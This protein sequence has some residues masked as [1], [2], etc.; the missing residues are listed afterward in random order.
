MSGR[1]FA[2][3]GLLLVIA[4]HPPAGGP[5]VQRD[6]TGGE[7]ERALHVLNRLAYGPRPGDV[8]RV[9]AMG[10]ERYIAEQLSP[11]EI[12]DRQLELRLR[13]F[14]L[15]SVSTT[16]LATLF[17][18]VRRERAEAARRLDTAQERRDVSGRAS[19][20]ALSEPAS[21]LRRL[22]GELRQIT[23]VRAALSER[24]LLEVMADFW[25]NHFNVFIRKGAGRVLVPAHIEEVIRPHVLG[26]FEDL[27]IAT[28]KSPAMLYYLDNVQSVSPDYQPPR[29]VNRTVHPRRRRPDRGTGTS[30]ADSTRGARRPRG[31][32]ENYARELLELHTL[33]VD[34]GYT[35]QDV[36]SVA[37][38]LT[39][40]TVRS[41]DDLR[42]AF[43]ARAHDFGEK[44][45]LGTR[46]SA[47]RGM[48]EGV[49][50]LRLLAAHPST[51]RHVSEKLCTRFVSDQPLPGCVDGAIQAWERTD[52]DIRQVLAAIFRSS[53]F[54]APE[55]RGTKMKTPLEF[56]VSAVRVLNAIPSADPGLAFALRRLGQPLYE[57][58]SPAGYPE[59]QESWVHA[60]ALLER[61][62][63]AVDLAAGTMPGVDV[64]LDDVVPVVGDP[65]H[66]TEAVDAVILTGMASAVTR[67]I[68]RERV[69]AARDPAEA[70]A[71]LVGLAIGSAEFQR[72]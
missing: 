37:R 5:S 25:T 51:R 9:M 41:R 69:D 29:R 10:V 40:W 16:D 1:S 22:M 24:Q 17:R 56:L 55:H 50:M 54:W 52:G 66:L 14:E 39:G 21:R 19:S 27:L 42:F 60:G 43:E 28:A 20:M 13:E 53:E 64:D 58:E 34:G 32:N 65:D 6:G 48:Q 68:L 62:N 11:E 18:T 23:I 31:L 33:G 67:R 15:M 72:Q 3:A 8:E 45:I 70:R 57:Y 30:Q 47:G 7:R 2:V 4:P 38:V 59:T 35:Q 44:T 36:V 63:I 61:F 71:L 46:F 26:R 49:E 12:P